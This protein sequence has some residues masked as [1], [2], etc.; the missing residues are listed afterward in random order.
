MLR[1]DPD[2]KL[3]LDEQDSII[4]NSTLTTHKTI[5]KIPTKSYVDSLHESSR[6]R[7]DLSSVF[8][9]QDNE[10]NNNKLPYFYSVTL[11]RNPSSNKEVSNKKYVDD[12]I[13]ECTIAKFNQTLE[14]GLKVF[15]G[16]DTHNLT[17]YDKIQTTDTALI[18]APKS[19]GY[20]LQNW[21][22]KCTDKNNAGKKQNFVRSTKTN[23]PTGDSRARTLPPIGDSFMCIETSSNIHGDNVFCSWEQTDI[24]QISNITFYYNRFSI[25]AYDFFKSMGRL[26]IQLLPQDNTWSTQKT[27]AKNTQYS[28]KSTDWTLLHLNLLKL[29]NR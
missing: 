27:I 17:K 8:N 23:S 1:L 19:G 22:I 3:N 13:G 9:D 28:D 26:R 6:N 4:L 16:N 20:L 7:R 5:I 15:V 18:I 11:N 10:F 14:N 29:N 2:E 21:V 12:S 24:F 25:L